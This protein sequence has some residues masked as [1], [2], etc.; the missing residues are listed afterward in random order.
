M[1]CNTSIALDKYRTLRITIRIETRK[2]DRNTEMKSDRPSGNFEVFGIGI[3]I[4]RWKLQLINR[5]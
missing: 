3:A 4:E 2:C 1:R 5:H